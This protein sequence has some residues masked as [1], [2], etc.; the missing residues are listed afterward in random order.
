[1]TNNS[2]KK[3]INRKNIIFFFT[4]VLAITLRIYLLGHE[5]LW[6][7]EAFTVLFS[8]KSLQDIFKEIKFE[9]HPPLYYLIMHFFLTLGD[10]E[11]MTRLPSLFFGVITIFFIFRIN[12]KENFTES[13]IAAGLFSISAQA[14]FISRMG[15][16]VLSKLPSCCFNC[17]LSKK[18]HLRRKQ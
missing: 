1:M 7:D 11:F 9:A 17:F 16:N 5:S 3:I 13:I 6:T 10:S 2:L 12:E 4:I 14:V 8:E 18:S 15:K